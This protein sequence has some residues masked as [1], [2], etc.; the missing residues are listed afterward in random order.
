MSSRKKT[1]SDVIVLNNFAFPECK[2][3]VFFLY[4]KELFRLASHRVPDC[5]ICGIVISKKSSN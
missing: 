1:V 5:V 4:Y 3:T 2:I